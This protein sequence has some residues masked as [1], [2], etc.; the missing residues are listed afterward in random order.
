MN[1]KEVQLMKKNILFAATLMA[2]LI[3]IAAAQDSR[4]PQ[5]SL[6]RE[7]DVQNARPSDGSRQPTPPRPRS[8]QLLQALLVLRR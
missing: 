2:A 1:K 5:A 8:T 7:M 4:L 6:N 3:P